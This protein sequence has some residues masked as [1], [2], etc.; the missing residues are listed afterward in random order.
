MSVPHFQACRAKLQDLREVSNTP[1]RKQHLWAFIFCL[2]FAIVLF[3]P[4]WR[5]PNTR[6]TDN[7]DGV[8]IA[9]T[10][11]W[12]QQVLL[13]NPVGL[14]NAPILAPLPSTY[15]FS[16]PFLTAALIGMPFWLITHQPI[17]S[18]TINTLLSLILTAFFGYLLV[19][20]VTQDFWR[21]LTAGFFI[22]YGITHLTFLGHLHVLMLQWILLGMWSWWRFVSISTVSVKSKLNR[23]YLFLISVSIAAQF[24]NSPFSGYLFMICFAA[25]FFNRNSLKV[26]WAQKKLIALFLLPTFILIGLFYLPFW[27]TAHIYHSYRSIYDAANFALSVNE[28]TSPLRLSRFYWL[29]WPLILSVLLKLLLKKKNNFISNRLANNFLL[30]GVAS[31]ILALGPV[32][33]WMSHTVKVPFPLFHLLPIPLPYLVAYYLIP[34]FS[35]FRTPTRWLMATQICLGMWLALVLPKRF[36]NPFTFLL[37]VTVIFW[38]AQP[39][40]SFQTLPSTAQYPAVYQAIQQL[41]NGS[42]LHLPTYTYDMPQAQKEVMRMLMGATADHPTYNGYSGYAPQYRMDEMV[43]MNQSPFQTLTQKV[44]VENK[45][46]YVVIHLD[47]IGKSDL[48]LANELSRVALYKDAKTIIVDAPY[49]QLACPG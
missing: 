38:E 6:V 22:S 16:D 31:T 37:L 48:N 21:S 42:I 15:T 41:P 36:F 20:E 27:Q 23:R 5:Y 13:N 26:A 2:L 18:L 14:Y 11:N 17:L 4:L 24:L 35:A 10:I 39:F 8:F 33:K 40:L 46:K 7:Y 9:W 49:F 43:W 44:I 3:W 25:V 30:A 12:T 19:W 1:H 47:E 34:G 32:I 29:I 28:L 45:I